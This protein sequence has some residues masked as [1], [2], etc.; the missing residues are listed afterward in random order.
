MCSPAHN[1]LTEVI[2]ERIRILP[3]FV[4][5]VKLPIRCLRL[6]S[7]PSVTLAQPVNA[8]PQCCMAHF[9]NRR[10]YRRWAQ[11][12]SLSPLVQPVKSRFVVFTLCFVPLYCRSLPLHRA[13][14][15]LALVS[16]SPQPSA[17]TGAGHKREVYHRLLNL[18]NP[19]SLFS[20]SV[21]YRLLRSLPLYRATPMLALVSL[22]PQPSASTV[23]GHKREVYHPSP[24]P[25]NLQHTV[26]YYLSRYISCT[27]S[28][29]H[30]R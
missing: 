6:R 11:A 25:S 7:Q 2:T 17:S 15:T 12:R 5:P 8:L 20:H 16:L 3:H 27:S 24:Y 22:S 18:S 30:C 19:A 26:C 13:T 1:H 28:H 21:S 4:L 9:G 23:A 14:P 10:I 29:L